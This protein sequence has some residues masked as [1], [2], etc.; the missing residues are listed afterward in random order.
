MRN[1]LL[2]SIV[3]IALALTQPAN[4][5]SHKHVQGIV[6]TLVNAAENKIVL[7]IKKDKQSLSYSLPQGTTITINEMPATLDQIHAGMQVISYTETDEHVLSQIDVDA[8]KG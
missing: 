4:A 5:K 1:K 6:V 2:L 3:L 7:T 8:A